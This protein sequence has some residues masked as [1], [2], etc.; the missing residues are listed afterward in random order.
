MDQLGSR[1]FC[2]RS[3]PCSSFSSQEYAVQ[4]L[5][6]KRRRRRTSKKELDML[7]SSF[8]GNPF[9]TVEEREVLAQKTYMS[10]REIQVWFQNRRQNERRRS[11]A[12]LGEP[13]VLAGSAIATG[14]STS[15][16]RPTLDRR[17]PTAQL[18]PE[19]ISKPAKKPNNDQ[20]AAIALVGLSKSDQLPGAR[21]QSPTDSSSQLESV[22][23]PQF[24]Y[25]SVNPEQGLFQMPYPGRVF[26]Q[27]PNGAGGFTLQPLQPVQFLQPQPIFM[28]PRPGTV[29]PTGPPMSLPGQP[30]VPIIV[31]GR[32]PMIPLIRTDLGPGAHTSGPTLIS[33]IG[34]GPPPSHL[35]LQ[36]AQMIPTQQQPA[37]LLSPVTATN[38]KGVAPRVGN[39]RRASKTPTIST[40]LLPTNQAGSGPTQ[41]AASPSGNGRECSL[42]TSQLE[43]SPSNSNNTHPAD[44]ANSPT[45]TL[46]VSNGRDLTSNSEKKRKRVGTRVVPTLTDQ[47]SAIPKGRLSKMFS[48]S[49]LIPARPE[50]LA[51]SIGLAAGPAPAAGGERI[52]QS[53]SEPKA[54]PRVALDD[55]ECGDAD[56]DADDN[57]GGGDQP[58]TTSPMVSDDPSPMTSE[59]S[60][61]VE[62]K[63]NRQTLNFSVESL[64]GRARV[65][66]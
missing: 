49:D 58:P 20:D 24:V 63:T 42:A 35:F 33:P 50:A 8:L 1:E 61:A 6:G 65:E 28:T 40:E 10:A 17:N 43:Y 56:A 37:P 16:A 52:S 13:E 36:P 60:A 53:P 47:S 66:T 15:E 46:C 59:D 21:L 27:V 3:Q 29:F 19:E 30:N 31:H 39:R 18:T 12:T 64:M 2:S 55:G 25:R 23:A 11:V 45:I 54:A 7:E 9:P 38:L 51:S 14:Q 48:I 5:T 22:G 57:G 44:V 4:G 32:P 34:A 26:V 41:S 62:Q